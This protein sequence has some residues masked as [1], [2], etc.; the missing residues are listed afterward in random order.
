MPLRTHPH[1]IFQRRD[2]A[3]VTAKDIQLE[4]FIFGDSSIFFPFN[5][6][7][8]GKLVPQNNLLV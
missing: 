1:C 5:P 4:A 8:L 6:T 2:H 3:Q 7:T